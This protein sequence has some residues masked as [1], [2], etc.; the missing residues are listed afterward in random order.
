VIMLE[1]LNNTAVE[2]DIEAIQHAMAFNP[3]AIR[4]TDTSAASTGDRPQAAD[5]SFVGYALPSA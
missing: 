2:A 4:R 1:F 5:R 3:R